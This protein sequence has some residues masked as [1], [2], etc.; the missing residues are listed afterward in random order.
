MP[1]TGYVDHG[2]D[3]E[4]GKID[5]T[6]RLFASLGMRPGIVHER[7]AGLTDLGSG[8]LLVAGLMTPLACAGVLGTMSVALVINHRHK[9]F[10]IFRL[11]E[12]YEY[13]MVLMLA[14]IG[15]SGV[16]S[17]RV[18]LDNVL[19]VFDPPGWS[20]LVICVAAGLGG[21]M[22]LLITCWGPNP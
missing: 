2:V 11:G 5:G 15:L 1:R 12:G 9:G 22:V 3:Q 6:G 4:C 20:G 7:L 13:V 16:G 19:G 17:G 21:A 18:S 10:F 8:I 14:A